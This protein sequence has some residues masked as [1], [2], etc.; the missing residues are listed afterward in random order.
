MII[1]PPSA[2]FAASELSRRARN[3]LKA[4][5]VDCGL[6]DVEVLQVCIIFTCQ[7]LDKEDLQRKFNSDTG[8]ETDDELDLFS[9]ECSDPD[10]SV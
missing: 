6:D 3:E 8:R 10:H 4:K 1:S 2:V 7:G 5:I 9:Y